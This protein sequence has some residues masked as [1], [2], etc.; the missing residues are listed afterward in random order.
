MSVNTHSD[1][2]VVRPAHSR[3][4][5]SSAP[6][7]GAV[8]GLIA[9][10]LMAMWSMGYAAYQGLG[11]FLPLKLIA[12]T[13]LGVN[14][15][16]GGFW[17]LLLGVLIHLSVSAGWGVVFGALARRLGVGASTALGG[18]YGLAVYLLMTF[19]VLPWIDP[20]MRARVEVTMTSFLIAHLVFGIAL[21][22]LTPVL[23][24]AASRHEVQRRDLATDRTRLPAH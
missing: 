4:H 19:L 1:T 12:A 3:T 18:I 20:V 9:G 6:V 14:A 16:I 10:V 22:L 8:A 13:F 5:R 2:T 11:F 24:G 17:V 15:I 21:G 23:R 7:A